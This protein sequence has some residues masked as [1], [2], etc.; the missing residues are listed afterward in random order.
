MLKKKRIF[1]FVLLLILTLSISIPAF[2]YL[3]TDDQFNYGVYPSLFTQSQY[4][5]FYCSVQ[6][7]HA[8]AI[9]VDTGGT[10]HTDRDDQDAGTWAEAQTG[11]YAASQWNS[12]Y[13]H[14]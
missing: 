9:I 4:S 7:H 10:T 5:D 6:D 1:S 13:G 2:A 3:H 14:D 12:Y 11:Y 8:T